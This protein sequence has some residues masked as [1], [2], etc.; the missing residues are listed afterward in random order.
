MLLLLQGQKIIEDGNRRVI[1]ELS[2]SLAV[3]QALDFIVVN[4]KKMYSRTK[5][6]NKVAKWYNNQIIWVP[7]YSEIPDTNRADEIARRGMII[8]FSES[9]MI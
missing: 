8:E 5:Y 4:S 7:G 2:D 9:W 3:I 6:I 1:I